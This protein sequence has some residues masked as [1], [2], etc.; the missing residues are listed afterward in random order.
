MRPSTELELA[1]RRRRCASALGRRAR[2]EEPLAGLADRVVGLVAVPVHDDRRRRGTSGACARPC[3]SWRRCRAPSRSG[4]R[5]APPPTSPGAGAAPHR[6]CSLAPRAAH[7]TRRARRAARRSSRH[8]RAARRPLAPAVRRPAPAAGVRPADGCRPARP[9]ASRQPVADPSRSLLRSV[10]RRRRAV[11]SDFLNPAFVDPALDCRAITFENPTGARGAGGTEHS[12][13][14]G[15]PSRRVRA[16]ERVVLADIAGRG[17]LRHLW[18]TFLPAPP[19]QMRGL[20]LEVFYG[21]ATEPSISVPALDFFGL[22]HG[23]PVA[24]SSALL[25]RARGARLQLLRPDALPR[26][27]ARRDRERRQSGHDRSTSRSTTR[28]SPTFP[29]SSGSC[30]SRSDARTRRRCARTSRSS[31]GSRAP[32]ASSAATSACACSTRATG[33]ARAR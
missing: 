23:R 20:I 15:A 8:P 28:S 17:V 21:D 3:P 12:G 11:C 27:G 4:P 2:V 24:F 10:G 1:E 25:T 30:M 31:T 26:R 7:R 6:R 13:R 5:R 9:L 33:T 29:M 18:M 14:K 22:P 16:G 32:A 19:E